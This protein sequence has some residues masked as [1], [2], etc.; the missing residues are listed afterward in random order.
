M[1]INACQFT[2]PVGP[3]VV[4]A[5][6]SD[7][8]S[9]VVAAGWCAADELWER[10]PAG[11]KG[12]QMSPNEVERLGSAHEP[13]VAYLNGSVEALAAVPVQQAGTD[14]QQ[15]VWEGLR[16]IPPG[17]TR[18]YRELAEATSKPKAIRAV[19]SAC[20]RNLI[21]PMV[22]CHR[23]LRSDGSLGGYYYGLEVKQ[24]LLAHEGVRS[25]ATS[26]ANSDKLTLRT[27]REAGNEG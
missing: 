10:L 19:G 7:N 1:T 11:M 8:E 15:Q 12:D 23:A 13:I 5:D 6:E 25:E 27:E 17:E 3:L 22:P 14:L 21:A 18:N 9:T 4:L 2:T 16:Q 26:N 20:G 24:W